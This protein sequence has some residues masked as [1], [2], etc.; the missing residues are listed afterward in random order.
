[1][2]SITAEDALVLRYKQFRSAF[3]QVMLVTMSCGVYKAL[4]LG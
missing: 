4:I 3:G 2:A 1:M